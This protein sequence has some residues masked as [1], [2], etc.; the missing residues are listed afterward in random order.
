MKVNLR[1]KDVRIS[2]FFRLNVFIFIII[3]I[4]L[5]FKIIGDGSYLFS[6]EY[7]LKIFRY[8]L[9]FAVLG[10]IVFLLVISNI[11]ISLFQSFIICMIVPF[12]QLLIR[13]CSLDSTLLLFLSWILCSIVFFYR[14]RGNLYMKVLLFT[15]AFCLIEFIPMPANFF[16]SIA[17]NKN[18]D[19]IFMKFITL[20]SSLS[21][22]SLV[23]YSNKKID[24]SIKMKEQLC[25]ERQVNKQ[26]S[27][28]NNSLQ[29]YIRDYGV[30][31]A[32]TERKRITREMH[33][34][35]GYHFTNIIALMNAAI[36]SGNKEWSVVEDI[37]HTTLNQAHEGLMDSRR[38][39][40]ELR[41]TFNMAGYSSIYREIY[42]ITRI[43]QDCTGIEIVVHWGNLS[44]GYKNAQIIAISRIIQECL[45]NS[46]KHGH[47][48]NVKISFWE[49]ENILSLV[50]EDNGQGS[51]NIVKGI[52]LSGME[53]R[54]SPF[55][56]KLKYG[57]QDIGFIIMI[58]VPIEREDL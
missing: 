6:S 47:A 55:G 33:D 16:E 30:E 56:G 14:C 13:F 58:E 12:F 19:L 27:T 45:V 18:K 41:D 9:M 37:L 8:S 29:S 34:A 2:P 46:V 44:N 23:E 43:F 51:K 25:Y 24:E 39:L 26:L 1:D 28:F 17:M 48:T 3:I 42:Q 32:E 50:V 57:N 40:H 53:E 52:G 10:D 35:N 4:G 21:F 11:N 38:V 5:V 31:S 49:S 54:L 20:F 22:G 36:S 7:Q 15:V